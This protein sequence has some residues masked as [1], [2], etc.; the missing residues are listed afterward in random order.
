VVVL[1]FVIVAEASGDAGGVAVTLVDEV[2]V[3]VEGD[4]DELAIGGGVVVLGT[5][6]VV[7][8]DAV[9]AGVVVLVVV[10]R[11]HPASATVPRARAAIQGV[12]LFMGS[13]LRWT[14]DDTR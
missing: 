1:F 10:V 9:G 12:S 13:P 5:T 11:S 14:S 7:S 8:L 3:S 2:V 4:V 6:T